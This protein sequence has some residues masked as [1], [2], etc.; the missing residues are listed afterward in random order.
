M[1]VE[2]KEVKHK[3]FLHVNIAKKKINMALFK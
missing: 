2:K 1:V 3:F